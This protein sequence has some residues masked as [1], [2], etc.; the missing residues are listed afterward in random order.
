MRLTSLPKTLHAGK[1]LV[2][3]RAML[4]RAINPSGVSARDAVAR[5]Q[6]VRRQSGHSAAARHQSVPLATLPVSPSQPTPSSRCLHLGAGAIFCVLRPPTLTTTATVPSACKKGRQFA[7]ALKG[8]LSQ[9]GYG[10]Y[11]AFVFA[12]SLYCKSSAQQR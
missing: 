4:W 5:H 12:V 7:M 8:T 10:D 6:S 3:Q 11:V 2:F 9:N 1:D